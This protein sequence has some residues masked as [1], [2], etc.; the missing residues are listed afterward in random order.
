MAIK[1]RR[2][3]G[4][5]SQTP[6]IPTREGAPV[7]MRLPKR[8]AAMSEE[9]QVARRCACPRSRQTRATRGPTAAAPAGSPR[10]A[11]RRSPCQP[12]ERG[13]GGAA[14]FRNA[15]P[16]PSRAREPRAR[17]PARRA[18]ASAPARAGAGAD[19]AAAAGADGDDASGRAR[20]PPAAAPRRPPQREAEWAGRQ[21][22]RQRARGP[23]D[24]GVSGDGAQAMS[25]STTRAARCRRRCSPRT[26][27]KSASRYARTSTASSPV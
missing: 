12:T 25:G 11:P 26:T 18:T 23:G 22:K 7:A 9:Q 8:L 19:G 24:E 21:A 3:G 1:A 20:P 15:A 5:L 14:A 2:G 27:A 16:P 4:A 6:P 10:P 13:M 17:S